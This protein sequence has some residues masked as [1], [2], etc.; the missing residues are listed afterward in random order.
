MSRKLVCLIS[1]VLVLGLTLTNTASAE[2]VGWW[3]LDEGSGT[4]AYDSS[5]NGH[6]GTLV[7]DPMWRPG[8]IGGALEFDGT[9]DVVELGAFDVVGPGITLAA[10]IKPDDFDIN[11]G[12]IIT[13]ANEWL[14]DDHWWM[15]STIA[16][17]GETRLR[18]RLK[19]TEGQTVPTLIASS[20]VIVTDEWQHVVATWDGTTMRLYLNGEETGSMAKGGDAVATDPSIKAAIGSQP[21][22]AFATD[23]SRVNKFFDGFIDDV[24]LYNG[25]L[26]QDEIQVL[27][28]GSGGYPFAFGPT[29]ADGVLYPDTWVNLSWS[30]G[31]FAVSHDVYFGD[32][33]DDV[34]D[35]TGDTFQGNQA[36][37]FLVVGFPGFALPDG[38]VPGTTYYWRIDEVNDT[39][40]NSPWKG[41]VWSFSVPPKTAYAPDPADA[42]EMVAPDV[43]LSWTGGFG[44]KLH[45]VYFGE[46]FDEVNNAA[47]G[48]PQGTATY[49]P[50][51]LKLA[52]T[53]YW[54][55]DEF[56]VID[57]HKGDIWSFTTEG[58]VG[59]PDPSNGAVD[60]KAPETLVLRVMTPECL[61]GILLTTGG[62]TRSI[63]PIQTVRGQASSGAS[64]RPTSLSWTILRPTM[65]L[66]PP[67]PI[68]T[69]YLTCG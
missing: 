57:T 14:A 66:T 38:L 53:Y 32:N 7:G 55:V 42:A 26:T 50:G 58:G 48:L 22:D 27:M 10:W 40:P 17:A 25:A 4:T 29:P 45:T 51:T 30:S 67:T 20:G 12:R 49:A 21:P 47:G 8:K 31:D 46:N 13:K 35:G 64:R 5:G 59:S 6:D 3:K 69:G 19:T 43:E 60:V 33:F 65:T 41:D 16:E 18:F 28:E 39:E 9:D 63:T 62:L 52:K 36:A 23:P 37:T 24:R 68:A 1:F 11:D 44:S 56:D 34:N 54:R 15:L 2:L 61:S